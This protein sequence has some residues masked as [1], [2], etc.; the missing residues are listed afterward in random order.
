MKQN[1]DT[2]KDGDKIIKSIKK[3]Y[4]IVINAEVHCT[5]TAQ[6]AVLIVRKKTAV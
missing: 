1:K 6:N 2:T 5:L 4:S 3:N